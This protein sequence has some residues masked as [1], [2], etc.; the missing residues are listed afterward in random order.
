MSNIV[1]DLQEIDLQSIEFLSYQESI[2]KLNNILD[3]ND[4]GRNVNS[5]IAFVVIALKAQAKILE[6]LNDQHLNCSIPWDK[7]T[8]LPSHPSMIADA[9]KYTKFFQCSEGIKSVLNSF[10]G[11][12]LFAE[13]KILCYC[14]SSLLK[15]HN[16][17]FG[18]MLNHVMRV[19]WTKGDYFFVIKQL[20]GVKCNNKEHPKNHYNFGKISQVMD[21]L[22]MIFISEVGFNLKSN[23][24]CYSHILNQMADQFN[25][26]EFS[27]QIASLA[28]EI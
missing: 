6:H 15:P 4:F 8:G 13:K 24:V 21:D 16:V 25:V 17:S 11:W 18:V 10:L 7:R 26:E 5:A 27:R 23:Q 1:S 9:Q 28:G 22:S 3:S 20:V 12:S 2:A 19:D 14:D